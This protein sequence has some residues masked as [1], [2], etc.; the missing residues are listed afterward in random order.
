MAGS[1]AAL[2]MADRL[3]GGNLGQIIAKY[4]RARAPWQAIADLLH[5][6]YGVEV[7]E[8]DYVAAIKDAR[9]QS[10]VAR[11]VREEL[12]ETRKRI[13]AELEAERA[14]TEAGSLT[15]YSN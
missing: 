13:K 2:R 5:S 11:K 15:F 6:D 1:K 10:A 4:R 7:K 12:E 8:M 9:L 14:K 3:A